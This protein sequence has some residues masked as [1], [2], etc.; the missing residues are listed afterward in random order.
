MIIHSYGNHSFD[1]QKAFFRSERYI[2]I[3]SIDFTRET[4]DFDIYTPAMSL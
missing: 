4:M 1:K 2:P 3:L